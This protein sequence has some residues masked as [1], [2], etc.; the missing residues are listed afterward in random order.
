MAKNVSKIG[1]EVVA[2][3]SGLSRGLAGAERRIAS[4][5]K[6]VSSVGGLGGALAGLGTGLSFAALAS[7][8][9]ST[10]SE[11]DAI[12]DRAKGL[13][14]TAENLRTIDYV[15]VRV[16]SN[17]EAAAMGIGKMTQ[18]LGEAATKGGDGAKAIKALGLDLASLIHMKPSEAF[19]SI[20]SAIGRLPDVYQKAAAAKAIFGKGAKDLM[21][22]FSDPTEIEAFIK[23]FDD[24]HGNVGKAADIAGTAQD[25]FDRL[26]E[27][28]KGFGE[29]A[30]IAFG[31]GVTGAVKE[32]A[33]WIGKLNNDE[34]GL[35]KAE[36]AVSGLSY[37]FEYGLPAIERWVNG[38]KG[39]ANLIKTESAMFILA[40][41]GLGLIPKSQ[42]GT[43]G[44]N[45]KK[46]DHY[47]LYGDKNIAKRVKD[48]NSGQ[49]RI[50]DQVGNEGVAGMN[51]AID[52]STKVIE[53]S[54][55]KTTDKTKE[56]AGAQGAVATALAASE[57]STKAIEAIWK[58]VET[59]IEEYFRK[60]DEL[61]AALGDNA[62]NSELYARA[63]S[64]YWNDAYDKMKR[65]TDGTKKSKEAMQ[66]TAQAGQA[67]LDQIN[68]IVDYNTAPGGNIGPR[69]PNTPYF[70]PPQW[71]PTQ[72]YSGAEID[73]ATN[74]AMTMVNTGED[75][76]M[77]EQ[78][79]WLK[80]IAENTA[81]S[82]AVL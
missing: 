59:P 48:A 18:S 27:A 56:L 23:D 60:M 52:K 61:D 73:A 29:N 66:G 67:M 26:S 6:S 75:P 70:T 51:A 11:L 31:P 22:F 34:D 14:D 41:E 39:V 21:P 8:L 82:G 74:R 28:M 65:M 80:Q 5:T 1:I 16:G 64:K 72:T 32:L 12:G 71:G 43:S 15:A 58:E 49:V 57:E 13:G 4:F 9:K 40:G 50:S 42:I 45:Q 76:Q 25:Q 62:D 79:Y 10:I 33:D 78:T 36:S 30:V 69:N 3:A 46:L 7:G 63:Q 17:A 37:A 20:A 24:L 68:A 2:N 81:D 55:S 77:D 44:V 38:I 54:I 35:G 53:Q 47:L 19:I